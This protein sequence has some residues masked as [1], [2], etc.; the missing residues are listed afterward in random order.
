MLDFFSEIFS[1]FGQWLVS[2]LP[3]SPFSEFIDVMNNL[4]FLNY[5]NWFIPVTS[6]L[7]VFVCWLSAISLF[8]VYSIIARW[9]KLLGD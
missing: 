6:I 4:P 1:K 8:Y 2:V 5:L 7:K 3:H 9:V